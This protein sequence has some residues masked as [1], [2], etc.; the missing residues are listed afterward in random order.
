MAIKK[1]LITSKSMSFDLIAVHAWNSENLEKCKNLM[2]MASGRI[3][4]SR[5][6]VGIGRMVL[7]NYGSFLFAKF[8]HER[9]YDIFVRR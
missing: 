8:I 9:K 7:P 3:K 2:K 1:S 4:I 6:I 5:T